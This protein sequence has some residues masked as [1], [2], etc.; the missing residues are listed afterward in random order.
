MWVLGT[1]VAPAV[2]QPKP[3]LGVTLTAAERCGLEPD[4]V[5]KAIAHELSVP[6]AATDGT[7]TLH[8]ACEAPGRV[9]VSYLGARGER[10]D[11]TLDPVER[12]A[13]GALTIALLVGNLA[14]DEAHAIVEELR[15]A[16]L[17][18]ATRAGGEPGADTADAAPPAPESEATRA[19]A[20]QPD[21]TAA[22]SAK[23][24]QAAEVPAKSPE[25]APA[26]SDAKAAP[27]RELRFYQAS[28]WPPLALD[29]DGTRFRYRVSM[30]ALYGHTG[31]ITDGVGASLGVERV[32]GDVRGALL[33]LVATHVDG[34]VHGARLAVGA[35]TGSGTLSGAEIATFANH[36]RGSVRGAQVASFYNYARSTLGV[37]A[38]LLN[39]SGDV[40]GVQAALVNVARDA[41][42]LQLG[43][44]NVSRRSAGLQLG[45]VN[46]SRERE[47]VG[48][49]LVSVSRDDDVSATVWHDYG[50]DMNVGVKLRSR[51]FYTQFGWGAEPSERLHAVSAGVGL[52]FGGRFFFEPDALYRS[53][54]D[55]TE[56]NSRDGHA[57]HVRGKLGYAVVDRR[58]ALFV[59]SGA[60]LPMDS[61]G[62][63]KD[64]APLWVLGVDAF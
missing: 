41:R 57:V 34:T 28:L 21:A 60:R 27:T 48:V 47:G 45:L 11:R 49:G 26:A 23:P 59:G 38:A 4:A 46:V 6:V 43:L 32:T 14:R 63:L 18:A 24:A 50:A 2:A 35:N 1:G 10:L 9:Q 36:Q 61:E 17:L 5:R 52:H 7:T 53:E 44:V 3:S 39:V 37:Q 12:G 19:A 22:A 30:S 40:G 15:A 62:R 64:P 56:Q 58:L 25:N 54:W 42:G 31:G 55:L 16:R 33:G 13:A 20:A 51:V 8:V 29:R